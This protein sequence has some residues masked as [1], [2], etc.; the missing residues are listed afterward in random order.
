[1][2]NR[3]C[4]SYQLSNRRLPVQMDVDEKIASGLATLPGWR[5]SNRNQQGGMFKTGWGND[6]SA[7]FYGGRDLA[8][9]P[10]ARRSSLT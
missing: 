3:L 10:I 4:G 9:T 7:H 1:M 2:R 8:D 5:P 6:G